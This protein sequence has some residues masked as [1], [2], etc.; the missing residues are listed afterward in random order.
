MGPHGSSTVHPTLRPAGRP[1]ADVID[2]SY[3]AGDP[4][5]ARLEDP[6]AAQ[7]AVHFTGPRVHR[8]VSDAGHNPS[9]QARDADAIL[10]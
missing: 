3:A 10:K 5:H 2:L 7:P 1:G 8:Q 6:L 4:A 9:Q